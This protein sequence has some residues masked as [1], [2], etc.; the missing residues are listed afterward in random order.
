[1]IKDTNIQI[2]IV[3]PKELNAKLKQEAKKQ[4]YGTTSQLI[5]KVL[6]DYIKDKEKET[7]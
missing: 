6:A 2:C 5:R 7:L 4:Y 3:I 1:M